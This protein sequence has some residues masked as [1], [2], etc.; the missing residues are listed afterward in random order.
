MYDISYIFLYYKL[1][2]DYLIQDRYSANELF[3]C[4][5][6]FASIYKIALFYFYASIKSLK[7]L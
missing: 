6:R 7:I 4:G 1:V 5:I 2:K 3:T